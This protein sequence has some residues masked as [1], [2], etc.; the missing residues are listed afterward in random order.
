MSRKHV[1]FFHLI[2]ANAMLIAGISHLY[3]E[4]L[5]HAVVRTT[6]NSLIPSVLCSFSHSATFTPETAINEQESFIRPVG[7]GGDIMLGCC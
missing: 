6:P 7:S 5:A 1:L 3:C 2:V 4:A